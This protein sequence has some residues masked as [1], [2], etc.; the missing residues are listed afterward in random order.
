MYCDGDRDVRQRESRNHDRGDRDAQPSLGNLTIAAAV[1]GPAEAG[2]LS[3]AVPRQN[4]NLLLKQL[5]EISP[6]SS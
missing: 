5:D 6:D 3:K 4:S 1:Y 2:L